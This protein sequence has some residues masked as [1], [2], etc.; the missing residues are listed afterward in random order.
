MLHICNLMGGILK[1]TPPAP[2]P[3]P[4]R[5][6]LHS[7]LVAAA[8][9]AA[10]PFWRSLRGTPAHLEILDP[11]SKLISE[12]PCGQKSPWSPSLPGSL[13]S[14]YG[15]GWKRGS[16]SRPQKQQSTCCHTETQITSLSSLLV[17]IWCPQL[18]SW[19]ALWTSC[20]P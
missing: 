11:P 2:P 8:S 14:L 9:V 3:F 7:S 16:H 17:Q 6:I 12:T 1:P 5:I 18:A 19:C 4:I 20:S 10:P 15:S 13:F